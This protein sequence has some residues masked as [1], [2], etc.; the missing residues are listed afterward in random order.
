[1]VL[2]HSKKDEPAGAAL[3]RMCDGFKQHNEAFECLEMLK[4]GFGLIDVSNFSL[5]EWTTFFGAHE[6]KQTLCDAKI[7]LLFC[8]SE[9]CLMCSAHVDDFRA[10]V[11][12]ADFKW[13]HQI[14]LEAFDGD[15]KMEIG[16]QFIHTGITHI[17]NE[18]A[19]SLYPVPASMFPTLGTEESLLRESPFQ[20]Y[21]TFLGAVAWL[22]QT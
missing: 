4:E 18:Y 14:L 6:L 2:P 10:T 21:L 7:Y 17:F 22:V 20:C 1:L 19:R 8:N 5:H 16:K 12:P 15:F 11:E 3:R 9:W 13:L